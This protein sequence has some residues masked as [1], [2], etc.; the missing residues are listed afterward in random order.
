MAHVPHSSSLEP[1]LVRRGSTVTPTKIESE[2]LNAPPHPNHLGET[3]PRPPL[4]FYEF[5]RRLYPANDR[6]L[7]TKVVYQSPHVLILRVVQWRSSMLIP[8]IWVMHNTRPAG[9]FLFVQLYPLTLI[10]CQT[11]GKT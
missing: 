1:A 4:T 5:A 9:R 2:R 8:L 11:K 10:I 7:P 3:M 6:Y